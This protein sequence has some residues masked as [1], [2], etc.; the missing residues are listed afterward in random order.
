MLSSPQ[1]RLY[2]SALSGMGGGNT[3]GAQR[4]DIGIIGGFLGNWLLYCLMTRWEG[5]AANFQV[6]ALSLGIRNFILLRDDEA[7]VISKAYM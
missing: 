2:K 1:S 3:T 4:Q 5:I 6:I 7:F